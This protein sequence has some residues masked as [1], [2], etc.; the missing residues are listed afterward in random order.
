M[1]ISAQE[2]ELLLEMV[3]D[4]ISRQVNW[5]KTKSDSHYKLF[6]AGQMKAVQHVLDLLAVNN[7]REAI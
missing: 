7:D 2:Y 1:K 3:Q 4:D 6:N 5:L